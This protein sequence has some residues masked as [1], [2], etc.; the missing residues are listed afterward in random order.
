MPTIFRM[1]TIV[2]ILS[3][4]ST[5]NYEKKFIT[6]GF[7]HCGTY[8]TDVFPDNST[9]EERQTYQS[10]MKELDQFLGPYPYDK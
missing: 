3:F 6:S 9:E 4:M 2:G 1:P 5:L 8:I 7:S 10:N